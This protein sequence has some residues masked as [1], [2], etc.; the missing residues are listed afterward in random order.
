V[1]T[2]R[3]RELA[4]SGVE[5]GAQWVAMDSSWR[6]N[7]SS[8]VWAN[9]LAIGNGFIRIEGLDPRDANLANRPTDPLV[10][11]GTGMS[12]RATQLLEADLVAGGEPIDALK[13]A[14]FTGGVLRVRPGQTLNAGSAALSTNG[15]LRNEGTINGNVECFT[16]TSAGTINGTLTCPSPPKPLPDPGIITI[17]RNLGA[18]ISPPSIVQNALLSPASNPWG[19][20]DPDGVYVIITS[21]DITLRNLR[22]VGTLV[23]VNGSKRVTVE[24]VNMMPARAD[25]PALLVQGDITL[26]FNGDGLLSEAIAGVNFNP[27]GSAF[28][29]ISNSN[30]SDS[31]PAEISGLV[32]ALGNVHFTANSRIRGTVISESTGGDALHVE[33]APEIVY[34]A[35]ILTTPIMG[36]MKSVNMTVVPGSWRQVVLP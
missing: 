2:I 25:Y 30:T 4:R 7:R 1:D 28:Q 17:Y 8:G 15:A 12:G 26:A 6:T 24:T 29:G 34:D 33:A 16:I 23:V 13:Y 14:V 22:V 10:I 11:R 18:V 36:Y 31:Y 20:P 32:H 5:L 3:A 35:G 21:S 19:E 27:P 9:S